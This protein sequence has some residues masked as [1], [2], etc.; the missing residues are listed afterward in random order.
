M[1]DTEKIN[2]KTIGISHMPVEDIV[3]LIVEESTNSINAVKNVEDK[4][5]FMVQFLYDKIINGGKIIYVGAGT[6]GRIAAQDVIELYPTY[7]LDDNTFDY[8]MVGGR[9]ALYQSVENSEDNKKQASI[10][11]KRRNLKKNDVVIGI[12]A[13]GR[14][15]Y[16]LS[17]INYA[18]SLDIYTVGIVNNINTEL[19]KVANYTI[20]LKT[21]AEVIQGSTRMNAGTSQKIL[22]NTISTSLAILLG[23]TLDNTMG[24]MKS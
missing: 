14:T 4:V 21:G 22:L 8:I 13:S 12:S 17:A 18:K 6:S 2:P 16:V 23:K 24:S 7:G 11:L 20:I 9:K 10:D 15:P 3:N 19:E 1:K 5:S